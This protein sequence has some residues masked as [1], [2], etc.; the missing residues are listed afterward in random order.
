MP[1]KII[2]ISYIIGGVYYGK[3]GP[4]PCRNIE[5][6]VQKIFDKNKNYKYVDLVYKPDGNTMNMKL[7]T[8]IVEC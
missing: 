7:A 1:I 6:Q 4:E 8:L 3:S 2:E 5:Q